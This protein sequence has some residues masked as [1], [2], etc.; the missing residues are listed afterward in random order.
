MSNGTKLLLIVGG[1]YALHL[2]RTAM[3]LL[4]V[5]VKLVGARIHK[6]TLTDLVLR[7]DVAL[8]NIS[9]Q[10]LTLNYINADMKLDGK[11]LGR[12]FHTFNSKLENFQTQKVTFEIEISNLSLVTSIYNAIK[13]KNFKNHVVG[14][15]GSLSVNGITFPIPSLSLNLEDYL[16]I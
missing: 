12:A 8:T 14:L 2:A 6:I 15:S 13:D 1:V 3:A 16:P 7:F 4:K 9:T 10:P 5:D 11:F